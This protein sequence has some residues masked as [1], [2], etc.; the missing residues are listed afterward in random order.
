MIPRLFLT[1]AE[2]LAQASG[3]AECRTAISRAYY[4]V[5]NTAERLLERMGFHRPKRNPHII[6]RQRLLNS[7]DAEFARIGSDLIEL[8]HARVQADYFLDNRD[9][10]KGSNAQGAVSTATT[11]IA[12]LDACPI[13]SERWKNMRTAIARANITGADNVIDTSSNP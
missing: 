13:H 9:P 11:M 12:A 3:P 2:D 6:L 4:A 8:H 10:E 7:G 1:L 5:F